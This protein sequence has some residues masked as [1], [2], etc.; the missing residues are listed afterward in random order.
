MIA[1]NSSA[2]QYPSTLSLTKT[3]QRINEL[4]QLGKERER[5][6]EREREKEKKREINKKKNSNN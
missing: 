5:E 6:R 2:Y 1:Y 3:T 4:H